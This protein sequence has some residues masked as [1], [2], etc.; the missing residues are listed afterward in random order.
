MRRESEH[1]EN[2]TLAYHCA[3]DFIL[4][5]FLF[6]KQ[7]CPSYVRGTD[8]PWKGAKNHA[9]HVKDHAGRR[10]VPRPVADRR[11]FY[12]SIWNSFAHSSRI[13]INDCSIYP[14]RPALRFRWFLALASWSVLFPFVLAIFFFLFFHLY[15]TVKIE[16]RGRNW[17][18]E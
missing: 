7:V 17:W 5:S 1:E 12:R 14:Y 16:C 10:L 3:N 18:N 4:I 13:D 9:R 6:R 11:P 2:S 8:A 15:T